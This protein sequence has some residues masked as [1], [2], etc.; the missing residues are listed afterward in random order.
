MVQVLIQRCF[1]IFTTVAIFLEGEK[2][3]KKQ[4]LEIQKKK[5]ETQLLKEKKRNEAKNDK[6]MREG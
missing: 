3:H 6:L 5:K 4:F 2:K 1:N